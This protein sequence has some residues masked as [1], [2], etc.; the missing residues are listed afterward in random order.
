LSTGLVVPGLAETTTALAYRAACRD[1]GRVLRGAFLL[2]NV[3][4][5]ALVAVALML[6]SG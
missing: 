1:T 4:L 5:N 6:N 3:W 2:L